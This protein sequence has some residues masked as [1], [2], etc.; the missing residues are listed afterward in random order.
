MYMHMHMYIYIPD[1]YLGNNV[2]NVSGS[3]RVGDVRLKLNVP[4]LVLGGLGLALSEKV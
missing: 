4:R 1:E 3:G 2:C